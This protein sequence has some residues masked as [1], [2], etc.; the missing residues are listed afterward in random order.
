LEEDEPHLQC[1]LNVFPTL[2]PLIEKKQVSRDSFIFT[3]GLNEAWKPLGL[4]TCAC[5]VAILDSEDGK[6]QRSYTP[7]STNTM[8]G[9][10]QLLIK[11]YPNG[12]FTQLLNQKSVGDLVGFTH[13]PHNVKIR[14][15]FG[16]RKLGMLAGGTGVAPMI[17]AL[18]AVFGLDKHTEVSL[19]YASRSEQD[20]LGMDVLDCFTTLFP[21]RVKITHVLSQESKD[22]KWTGL[23]GRIT[24]TM[25]QEHMPPPADDVL[26]FVCG[27]RSMYEDI[28]G[29]RMSK[30]VTG[31]LGALGYESKH[32]YKF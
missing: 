14:H 21:N 15:P 5:V 11:I 25:I 30:D 8:I 12:E 18:N 17:Q 16:K 1:Q 10:F 20:I 2:L 6:I 9:K 32:V 22:S 24:Q 29:R 26:V 13:S 19:L 7:I 4:S 28:C 3:F 31:Y 27:P 23:R